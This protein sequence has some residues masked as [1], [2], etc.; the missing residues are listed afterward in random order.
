VRGNI[1][2]AADRL[3][4]AIAD[5]SRAIELRPDF[6][7]AYQARGQARRAA[8]DTDGALADLDKAV[9]LQFAP[10]KR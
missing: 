5:Y 8:G 7:P 3:S 1:H 10:K 9:E 2:R 6:L 4:D